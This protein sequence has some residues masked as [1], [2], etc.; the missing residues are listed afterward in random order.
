[1]KIKYA[2]EVDALYITLTDKE[3]ED[4]DEVSKDL[5][6]DYDKD[7]DVVGVEVLNASL[8]KDLEGIIKQYIKRVKAA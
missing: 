1:M 6:V 3:I 7:G 8:N 5:V 2:A 4:T